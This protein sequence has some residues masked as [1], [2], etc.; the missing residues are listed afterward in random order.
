MKCGW[1][2]G[3]QLA[4]A[5]R[6]PPWAVA[7][8]PALPS[9][10][11]SMPSSTTS[12]GSEPQVVGCNFTHPRPRTVPKGP[13]CFCHHR[14]FRLTHP[15]LVVSTPHRSGLW[16]R[17]LYTH[18]H[19]HTHSCRSVLLAPTHMTAPPT[20]LNP[21]PSSAP[22]PTRYLTLCTSPCI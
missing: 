21:F 15:H 5:S 6:S 13:Y 20:G 12:V 16:L 19:T 2:I 1:G 3:H 22:C 9:S 4:S 14:D 17:G 10:L 18:T 8:E 11:Q 7:L